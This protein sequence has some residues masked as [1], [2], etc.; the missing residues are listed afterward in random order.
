MQKKAALACAV[1]LALA[2]AGCAQNP[3]PAP[4]AAPVVNAT[5]PPL[6]PDPAL[7]TP[8]QPSQAAG[9]SRRRR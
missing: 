3:P 9:T 8:S 6:P 7:G 5:P 4:P 1:L 2:I